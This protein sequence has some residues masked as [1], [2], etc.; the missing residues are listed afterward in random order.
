[1]KVP[2]NRPLITAEDQQAVLQALQ[3]T[4]ISGETPIVQQMEKSLA[5]FLGVREVVSVSSG[6]TALDLSIEALEISN[7]DECIVPSF[8]IISTVSNL[9]RKGAKLKLVDSDPITWQ[10]D[11]Q[12]T[13]EA[14]SKQTKLFL[15][16]HTYGLAVDLHQIKEAL[17]EDCFTLE[18]AAET[19]GLNYQGKQT[20]SIGDAGIFSF[21]ANK[22]VTGGEGGA[23]ATSNVEFA[24]KIRY[25]KNL[26]FNSE[27]RFVHRDLGWNGRIAGLSAA[28]I[29]SQLSRVDH[30]LAK[31]REI[32]AFYLEGLKDH[33]W[34]E[35]MPTSLPHADNTFWVFPVILN[36]ESNHNARELQIVL[37][38]MGIETRRFFCP[39]H[40]QPLI[41]SYNYEQIGSMKVSEKLWERGIYLPSGLG[42]T[43]EELQKVVDTFWTLIK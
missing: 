33:P 25:L 5:E 36:K 37:K 9:L 13:L 12:L 42:N 7:Q 32:A 34:L 4:M 38:S 2:V 35:F 18:D 27:E 15:P 43:N 23:I 22:I 6:T 30:L 39:I 31:K 8:T 28:L 20:G 40:L 19:L 3:E 17:P 16:V 11:T 24:R 29:N 21:Y 1:M 26:C 10:M 14:I 41:N